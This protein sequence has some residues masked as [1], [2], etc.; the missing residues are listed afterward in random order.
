LYDINE[1]TLRTWIH[2]WNRQGIDGLTE[3]PMPGRPRK[4][5]QGYT[6]RLVDLIHNPDKAEMAHWTAKKFHGYLREEIELDVGYRTVV[7][8]L[9]EH[10]FR[11]KVPQ[12][13]SDR[14]DE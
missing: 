9:H 3:K 2:E 1:R 12:P 11:L 13:W 8:W 4:I 7:R 14:Q 10:D 5:P 6:E